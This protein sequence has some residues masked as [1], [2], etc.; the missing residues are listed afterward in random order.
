M[1]DSS[2]SGVLLGLLRLLLLRTILGEVSSFATMETGSH[3]DS[4][5]LPLRLQLI[6]LHR[7]RCLVLLLLSLVCWTWCLDVL[8][9]LLL[10]TLLLI[11]WRRLTIH[12]P[13]WPL[14]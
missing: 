8:T 10:L 3:S 4:G 13:L 11:L 14:L 5:R 12:L 1:V 2:T 7:T 6:L 9:R